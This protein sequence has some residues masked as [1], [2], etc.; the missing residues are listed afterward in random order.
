MRE[1]RMDHPEPPVMLEV[2]EATMSSPMLRDEPVLPVDP[3]EL[4]L[5]PATFPEM[6]I[7]QP[8]TVAM[9]VELAI[10]VTVAVAASFVAA[11]VRVAIAIGSLGVVAIGIRWIDRHVSFSFGEGFVGYR[12]DLGWPRGIQ[13]DDDVRWNW[14]G[15]TAGTGSPVTPQVF[16][17]N[18]MDKASRGR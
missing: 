12:A 8:M 9:R 17:V 13:E 14:R 5:A 1:T 2:V 6:P 3:V 4:D 15:S 16:F 7:L 10:V 11:D 18:P